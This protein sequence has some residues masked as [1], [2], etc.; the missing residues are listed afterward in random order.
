MA[1]RES[2]EAVEDERSLDRGVQAGAGAYRGNPYP[3]TEQVQGLDG[4]ACLLAAQHG[5]GA[6]PGGG[7]ISQPGR[8]VGQLRAR[9]QGA[10]PIL[11]N[12]VVSRG[13][14]VLWPTTGSRPG[15]KTGS[16]LTS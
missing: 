3:H 10:T 15:R 1:V 6:L 4:N 12:D 13:T 9:E 8:F 5:D 16:R 11:G 7:Q 14:H 2:S